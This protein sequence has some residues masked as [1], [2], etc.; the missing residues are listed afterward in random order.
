V[1]LSR[2]D[3]G[4]STGA[5]PLSSSIAVTVQ[6]WTARVEVLSHGNTQAEIREK[7]ALHFDAGVREGLN[8]KTAKSAKELLIEP[9][10]FAL[11]AVFA[12]NS[13]ADRGKN[14]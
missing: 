5:R 13:G 7:M 11:L 2:S 10:H 8:A 3:P 12:F 4:P 1:G 9:S 6:A 14:G